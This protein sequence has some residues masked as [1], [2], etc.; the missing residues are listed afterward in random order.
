MATLAKRL[1]S[2]VALNG[3]N[4]SLKNSLR[5]RNASVLATASPKTLSRIGRSYGLGRSGTAFFVAVMLASSQIASGNPIS[6]SSVVAVANAANHTNAGP[7]GQYMGSNKSNLALASP[8]A[9]SNALD[10]SVELV[11][12]SVKPDTFACSF[13][14]SNEN[15]K[16]AGSSR[17]WRGRNISAQELNKMTATVQKVCESQ[18]KQA[19][20][21]AVA[22]AQSAGT[23][24]ATLSTAGMKEYVSTQLNLAQSQLNAQTTALERA[25]AALNK[26]KQNRESNQAKHNANLAAA[27][28]KFNANLQAFKN[29]QTMWKSVRNAKTRIVQGTGK[30]LSTIPEAGGQVGE[31]I[32][33]GL[34]AINSY[35][36]LALCLVF[37]VCVLLS[38]GYIEL[39][40]FGMI[41]TSIRKLFKL[42]RNLKADDVAKPIAKLAK[43]ID[44]GVQTNALNRKNASTNVLE[45]LNVASNV[46]NNRRQANQRQ[47]AATRIQAAAR[48]LL[49]RRQAARRRTAMAQ[50][51]APVNNEAAR[52]AQYNKR[53]AEV[54]AT[55]RAAI[56]RRIQQSN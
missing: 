5:N 15:W 56:S 35:R 54:L 7:L 16:R 41:S 18:R 17:N 38:Y 34:E 36:R 30:I 6:R 9:V 51:Q 4:A 43:M 31:F 3:T 50:R 48:G 40:T 44:A 12:N 33:G 39:F 37:G 23:A 29:S 21:A 14:Y 24:I 27:K 45:I 42:R 53:R 25:Q 19:G 32:T 8:A 1:N 49:A 20:Q 10:A 2:G 11:V 55:R 46:V 22:V 13:T 28:A 26:V 52:A 47:V